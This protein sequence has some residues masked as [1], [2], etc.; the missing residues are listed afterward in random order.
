M[1]LPGICNEDRQ[2]RVFIEN[3]L[4]ATVIDALLTTIPTIF[5]TT[6][7]T[8]II[9]VTTL[10]LP[11]DIIGG[12]LVRRSCWCRL[13]VIG[14]LDLVSGQL[15][16]VIRGTNGEKLRSNEVNLINE[17]L[18]DQR[19]RMDCCL[20]RST[21]CLVV[22]MGQPAQCPPP[23]KGKLRLITSYYRCKTPIQT[24]TAM[25]KEASTRGKA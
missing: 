20:R 9:I 16:S 8:G 7:T 13:A 11:R 14:S 18:S 25:P 1:I 24:A 12:V 21:W 19:R 23:A 17:D 15:A 2:L 22:R 5:L 3:L 6:V 10:R 4:D